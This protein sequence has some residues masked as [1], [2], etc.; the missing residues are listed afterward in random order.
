MNM[1]KFMNME[2][3]TKLPTSMS[4]NLPWSQ[5]VHICHLLKSRTDSKCSMSVVIAS[6]CSFLT[7]QCSALNGLGLEQSR[8]GPIAADFLHSMGQMAH[9]N[10]GS[11]SESGS[12][13]ETPDQVRRSTTTGD[14]NSVT[15]V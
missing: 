4:Q 2:T 11:F 12:T 8:Q 13:R 9:V 14:F 6:S 7:F 15:L 10:N 3:G 5:R 1:I